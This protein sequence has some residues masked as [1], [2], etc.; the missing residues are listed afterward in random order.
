MFHVKR[1]GVEHMCEVVRGRF[2]SLVSST[3]PQRE[4]DLAAHAERMIANL[5]Q[6]FEDA[7]GLPPDEADQVV[8]NGCL[9]HILFRFMARADGLTQIREI[10]PELVSLI[11]QHHKQRARG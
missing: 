4:M 8:I 10:A 5:T 11:E 9:E 2:G 7:G 6:L 1:A 3:A